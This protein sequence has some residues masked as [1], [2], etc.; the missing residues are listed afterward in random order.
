MND[1]PRSAI[2]VLLCCGCAGVSPRVP[3]ETYAVTPLESGATTS[4]RGVSVVDA[5]VVWASGSGGVVLRSTDGGARWV[6]RSVPGADS[7]DFRD[8]EA[9][10]SLTAYVLS[11][12][13]DGRIYKTVD[14]GLS[15]QLQFQNETKGAFFD[16]FDFWDA[17][18]GIAMSDPVAGRFL[19]IRTDDGETWRAIASAN[20]PP[21]L[22][23]EAAFAASG[24][25]LVT[26]GSQRVY[27]GTGGGAEARV[28]V[29]D[30]RG[31]SWRAV[32]TPV[33]A[34]TASAGT[35]SLAFRDANHGMAIGGDYQQPAA[36]AVVARTSDGGATW[37][38]AGRTS[39]V[40]GA[41]YG[42]GS[43]VFAVGT[44]GTRVSHDDGMTWISLDTVEYNAVEF[45]GDGV[46]YAVGPRG[47][48]AKIGRR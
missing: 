39:Y 19:L 31:S 14:G 46:G 38:A 35:F 9:L 41:A 18:H 44:S 29:S 47:R 34:G 11:A 22:D 6:A 36:E 37:T 23:G 5:R 1:L 10:D 43:T 3:I 30:D 33:A 40:S 4:M 8:I 13:E 28:L 24:T 7:L 48:I 25:C 21:V 45:S 2:L 27:L 17:N 16:C 15:W 26:A 32:A 20:L 42:R 12:G